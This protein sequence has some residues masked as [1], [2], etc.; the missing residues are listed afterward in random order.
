MALRA[1]TSFLTDGGRVLA[2]C[3]A[4]ERTVL[5]RGLGN[6]RISKQQRRVWKEAHDQN[7]WFA[8]TGLNMVSCGA[9]SAVVCAHFCQMVNG[10]DASDVS[11]S[12]KRSVGVVRDLLERWKLPDDSDNGLYQRAL[13]V[14]IAALERAHR[15][16][17]AAEATA[18]EEMLD[19]D[20]ALALQLQYVRNSAFLTDPVVEENGDE[21]FGLVTAGLD[22][23]DDGESTVTSSGSS[24]SSLSEFD[25]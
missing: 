9:T 13:K 10:M 12:L 24:S 18:S 22:G 20:A 15:A 8:R 14:E 5:V 25:F 2:K 21:V 17:E 16:C 6:V 11:A 7:S 19:N 4:R 1:C 3:G 23:V